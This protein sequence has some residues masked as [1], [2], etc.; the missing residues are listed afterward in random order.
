ML[1]NPSSISG[2][3]NPRVFRET[4]C[5]P[6]AAAGAQWPAEHEVSFTTTTDRLSLQAVSHDA[7]DGLPEVSMALAKLY[8]CT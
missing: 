8:H 7:V 4:Q 6:P 2:P 5:Q 1:L 3:V